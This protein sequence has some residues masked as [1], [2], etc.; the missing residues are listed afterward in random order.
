MGSS[1]LSSFTSAKG[2]W[3]AAAVTAAPSSAADGAVTWHA[4]PAGSCSPP[5]SPTPGSSNRGDDGGGTRAGVGG[6]GEEG[7][8]GDLDIGGGTHWL[9]AWSLSEGGC[10]NTQNTHTHTYIHIVCILPRNHHG[11]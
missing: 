10:I 6:S 5:T 9:D 4:T 7:A 1:M 11:R 8:R 3:V 2:I